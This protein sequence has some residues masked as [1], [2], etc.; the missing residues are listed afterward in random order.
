ML[1]PHSPPPLCGPSRLRHRGPRAFRGLAGGILAALPLCAAAQ[2]ASQ[3][4]DDPPLAPFAPLCPSDLRAGAGPFVKETK[5][6]P[7]AK[8]DIATDRAT[9]DLNGNAHLQ[10]NVVVRQGDREVRANEAHY[11]R[12]T[13]NLTVRGSVTYQDPI[14][15]LSGS[16]GKYSPTAGTQVHSAQFGLIQRYGRGSANLLDLTP[17]GILDL[18]GVR[19]TTCPA[20]DQSWELKA[21]D[22]S[23]DTNRQ[24]GTGRNAVVDFQGVPVLYL[25]WFSFPLSNE[26]KSG[27][28]FPSAGNS[29]VNGFELQVPYYWNIAPNADLTFSPM[30]YSYRGVD[31]AGE[32]RFLTEE[33]TGQLEWNFLPND[34]RF[35][36]EESGL[37]TAGREADL[38]VTAIGGA[39]RSFVTFHDVVNLP[40]DLRVLIDAANVSDPLYFQDFGSGPETTSTAF[41]QRLAQLTYRDE[42]W[43]LGAAAQQYQPVSV[44]LPVPSEYLPDQYRPYARAPWLWGDGEFSWGPADLIRYGFDSE[45]VDF[46][47]SGLSGW[48]LDLTPHVGLDYEDPGYFIRSTL[49]YRYTQYELSNTLPDQDRSPS[50]ELPIASF[51]TGLKLERPW[52]EEDRTLTLEPRLFYLYVPYRNQSDL[53]LFDTALPDLNTVELFRD[54]R[55]VGADRMSDANQVTLGMTSRF[56]A[57]DTGQQFFSATLGQAYYLQTPRVEL[58]GETLDGRTDSDLVGDFVLTAYRNWD[59]DVNLQWNPATSQEERT[60]VQLQFKPGSESVINVAYRYQRDVVLPSALATPGEIP[61]VLGGVALPQSFT[62]NQSLNQAEVST[63][64]PIASG[65]HLLGRWVYD[66]EGH[67]GIDRLA[68]FEYRACCWR[69]R[70][71]YRRY[72]INGTGQEDTAFMFQIQLSG[73][74]GVGPATDAFLGTAIQG[75]SPPSLT[76]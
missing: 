72:L 20:A 38:P 55:Y 43:N 50:R 46:I 70:L 3:L 45:L 31:L 28:L 58:P 33:Q 16:D 21:A 68:G 39:D 19:F 40:D 49:D 4:L 7:N 74:A 1:P 54:N 36:S 6:N 27:F 65:W 29:S 30:I 15:R 52:S 44:E 13:G 24:Y 59:V 35:D 60:F 22:L 57:S 26:R 37:L 5:P 66:F 56:V 32:A 67:E 12:A 23:L 9:Y 41:L 71:L 11:D 62:E 34:Q 53:P 76:R 63:A 75:Y 73:L 17:Q 69:V 48:R 10:G 8:L 2:S 18:R 25:P 14:V 61:A 51:D 47:R 64:W 42:H